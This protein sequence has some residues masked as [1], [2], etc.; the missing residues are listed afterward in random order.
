MK[1]R[2]RGKGEREDGEG[3]GEMLTRG[4]TPN[5][6]DT[7]EIEDGRESGGSGTN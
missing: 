5:N 4:N 3:G 2:T 1:A 7:G 6:Y